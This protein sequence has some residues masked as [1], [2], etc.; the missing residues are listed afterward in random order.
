LQY[1]KPEEARRL[2]VLSQ[3]AAGRALGVT[4]PVQ[5]AGGAE[6]PTEEFKDRVRQFQKENGLKETGE[7]DARTR[8]SIGRMQLRNKEVVVPPAA[9]GTT[10]PVNPAA[11]AA[12]QALVVTPQA[13]TPVIEVRTTTAEMLALPASP[14]T[15]EIIHANRAKAM[16]A[17]EK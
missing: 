2:R 15:V 4:V 3:V 11:V 10:T 13:T 7:L 17:R 1:A 6:R 8:E 5:G 12:S 14:Q 9:S 16:R